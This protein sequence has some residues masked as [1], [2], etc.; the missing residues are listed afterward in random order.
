MTD[1]GTKLEQAQSALD[2]NLGNA[3]EQDRRDA[4]RRAEARVAREE[5]AEYSAL[6]DEARSLGIDT[7]ATDETAVD[8][9]AVAK[10]AE[11]VRLAK[12]VAGTHEYDGP[13]V[14]G[15]FVS[16]VAKGP[17]YETRFSGIY[18]GVR[19]SEGEPYHYF[20]D[21][22]IGETPQGFFGHPVA[23]SVGFL[24]RLPDGSLAAPVMVGEYGDDIACPVCGDSVDGNLWAHDGEADLADH[25]ECPTC[26]ALCDLVRGNDPTK[27]Q[28]GVDVATAGVSS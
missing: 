6:C 20:R 21:G 22:I 11:A 14:V 1:R 4:L 27:T 16:G 26:H 8:E 15:E 23:P 28:N 13:L 10:L 5:A 12:D 2:R 3:T 18:D 24:L 9:D 25:L 7:V 17:G 19:D